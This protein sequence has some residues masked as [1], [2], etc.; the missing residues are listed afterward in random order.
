MRRA[1]RRGWPTG[2]L[3][4]LRNPD[5]KR[6]LTKAE[7]GQLRGEI[8]HAYFIFGVD[9]KAIGE[10]RHAIGVGK[11]DAWLG[12]WAGGLA[13]WRSG[14]YELAGK[15][16]RSLVDLPKISAGRRRAAAFWAHRAELR[17]GSASKSVKYLTIAAQEIDSFYG[18]VARE[19][20]GQKITLSFDL[21][22]YDNKFLPWLAA[23]AGGQRLF[24]LLQIGK[25]HLAERELRYLW[26]E[27]PEEFHH[28]AMRLAAKHGMAG[29]SFRIAEI[30][31]KETDKSWYGAPIRIRH[32]KLILALMK[33]LYG[34]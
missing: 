13:A 21:P 25:T 6:Y 20:L 8:A 15:F 28:S 26:M 4:V 7:E 18:V 33:R 31:R 2:A 30:I 22:P 27:M 11:S 16:F 12:Y 32:S 34:Q 3:E 17:T 9:A 24:A 5:N 19:A 29:L 14:Q 1:I 23:R 10:A